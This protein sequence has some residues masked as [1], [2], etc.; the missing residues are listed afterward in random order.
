MT[1]L[2]TKWKFEN[3]PEP[4]GVLLIMYNVSSERFLVCLFLTSFS[5]KYKLPLN[6]IFNVWL[7]YSTS[8]SLLFRKWLKDNENNIPEYFGGKAKDDDKR[9]LYRMVSIFYK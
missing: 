4:G 5:L 8:E 3:K 6:K 7:K 9:F 2:K 1:W